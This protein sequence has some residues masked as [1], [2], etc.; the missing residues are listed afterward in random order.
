MPFFIDEEGDI[1]K[2]GAFFIVFM[3]CSLYTNAFLYAFRVYLCGVVEEKTSSLFDV[4][5]GNLGSIVA[6]QNS[7]K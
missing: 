6:R 2:I 1:G 4:G 5:G 3:W 7:I